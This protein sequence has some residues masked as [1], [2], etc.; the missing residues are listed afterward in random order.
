VLTLTGQLVNVVGTRTLRFDLRDWLVSVLADGEFRGRWAEVITWA[1]EQGQ[2][3]LDVEII[4]IA[5]R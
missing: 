3:L 4:R 2:G 5:K 1:G